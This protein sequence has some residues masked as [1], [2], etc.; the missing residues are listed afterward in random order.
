MTSTHVA[1][2][3]LPSLPLAA[4]TCH[5]FPQLKSGSLLS[6]GKLCDHGCEAIFTAK[7]VL[8]TRDGTTILQGTRSGPYGQWHVTLPTTSSPPQEMPPCPVAQA[9]TPAPGHLL[10]DRI[11]FYH[12]ALFSPV[13]STWCDAIDAGHFTTWPALTSAQVR[14]HFHWSIPMHLSHMHQTRA[15]IQSTKQPPSNSDS[16]STPIHV[17]THEI[18]VDIHPA[19][20]K[21]QSDQTGRFTTTSTSG[22][23]YLMVIYGYDSNFIHVEPLK[24]RSGPCILTAYKTAHHLFTSRGFQPRLQRLDNEAS[25]ALLQFMASNNIDVQLSPPHIHRRN[26]AERAIRTFKNHFIAGLCS[27]DLDCPMNLWDRLLPQA[28]Q[29]LNL[30]RT[31][32]LH[33]QRSAY[34]HVHGRFDFNRTPLAPPGM[35]VLIH[36][37][38]SIRGTW[39]PHAVPPPTFLSPANSIC[40]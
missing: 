34:A 16:S 5:L 21:V 20:G 18:F 37:K 7:A 25:T 10:S 9:I 24:S 30:L 2:L 26:A 23:S 3:P 33:P 35:K 38:P 12:A 11:A 36:E 40:N 13:L 6:I 14:K 22:N 1:E 29:T 15:N 32:R 8:V 19:T 4:R 39:A 31:S 27:N 17:R 28:I